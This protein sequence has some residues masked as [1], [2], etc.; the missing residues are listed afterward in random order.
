MKDRIPTLPSR[1]SRLRHFLLCLGFA[2]PALL[3]AQTAVVSSGSEFTAVVDPSGNLFTYGA[4]GSGQLGVPDAGA[5]SAGV[6]LV[7]PTGDWETVS[8]SKTGDSTGHVLAIRDGDLYAWG[9]NERGQ[10]GLGDTEQRDSPTLVDNT[11]TWV[12]VAAGA[13]FS[14]GRTATGAVWVWG[15][16]TQGQLA[17][18]IFNNASVDIELSPVPFE[19]GETYR[20]IAA[21]PRVGLAVRDDGALFAWGFSV[22]LQLGQPRNSPGAEIT[23]PA[24]EPQRIGTS[25]A[26]TE[27]FAGRTI[28]FGLRDGELYTWGAGGHTGVGFSPYTP[29]R[30]GNADDWATVAIGAGH[31]LGLRED[32]SL[33]GWGDNNQGALGLK[34]R[35]P[36]GEILTDNFFKTFPTAL[37]TDSTFLAVGAGADFSAIYSSEQFLLSAGINDRGQLGNGT[38]SDSGFQDFFNN[39]TLGLADLV[40]VSATTT[41]PEP[42]PGGTLD[43]NVFLRNEGTGT[44]TTDFELAAVLSPTPDRH[45]RHRAR[46][47]NQ[48]R[49]DPVVTAERGQRQLFSGGARGCERGADRGNDRQQRRGEPR[50]TGE[51]TRF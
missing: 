8:A 47:R 29:A 14:I 31:T 1:F 39:S 7:E 51:K 16:N 36:S 25:L 6:Q 15:D 50:R 34:Q 46:G 45:R 44:I 19:L 49:G 13:D 21:G 27:V 11:Q 33:Y 37:Q 41:T 42:S 23:G 35:T 9:S 48:P 30:V 28:C 17:R 24:T 18:T 43:A 4:N 3:Q 2:V 32:G 5:F 20:S 12:E 40:A 22:N 38:S 10:L 26:W